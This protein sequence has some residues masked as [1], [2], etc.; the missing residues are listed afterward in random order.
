[1]LQQM[2]NCNAT[3]ALADRFKLCGNKNYTVYNVTEAEHAAVRLV[4]DEG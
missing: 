2:K 1:M 3:L 4:D